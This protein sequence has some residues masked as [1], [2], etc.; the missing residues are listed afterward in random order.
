[1]ANLSNGAIDILMATY[2]GEKF[3]DTQITSIINQTYP[4]WK[5]YIHDDG[6]SDRT[7]ELIQKWCEIDERIIFIDDGISYRNPAQNFMHLL[8]YSKAEYVCFADQDDYW[9]EY[10]L[11][12]MLIKFESNSG[13]M[14]LFSSCF[15]WNTERNTIVPKIQFT[16]AYSLEEFLFLNSGIQGCAMFFNAEL[17]NIILSH[18][19][20]YVYMHDHLISLVAY[21]FGTV[22]YTAEPLILYRQYNGNT[23]AH[24]AESKFARFKLIASHNSV[25]VVYTPVYKGIEAFYHAYREELSDESK[26]NLSK[27]LKLPL[28]SFWKCFFTLIISPFSLGHRGKIA[29]M[30]K[31]LIRPFC[32]GDILERKE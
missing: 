29:L 9:L 25:P 26:A 30:V 1:M 14:L 8:P 17:R 7:K 20:D 16:P 28:L 22:L 21:E 18:P 4:C 24:V 10:K 12:R 15:L 5:L 2:N 13:A 11:E 27:Y 31:I 32:N 6:S 3:L 23:T 19:V